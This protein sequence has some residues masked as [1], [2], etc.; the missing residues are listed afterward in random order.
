V[1]GCVITGRCPH[2]STGAST[3]RDNGRQCGG[4]SAAN[5]VISRDTVGSEATAPN[6]PGSARSRPISAKQSPPMASATARSQTILPGSWLASGLRQGDNAV[7]NAPIRPL[8]SAVRASAT[9]PAC[10]TTP[11]P[12]ADADNDG[13]RDVDLPT[14]MVLRSSGLTRTSAIPIIP[15]QSTL[16]YERH[17]ATSQ[18]G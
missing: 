17:T 16:L 15:V 8:R 9:A 10:D 14:R 3:R 18:L 12:V 6:T 1:V 11:R 5:A 4:A 2:R 13:Y 7:D